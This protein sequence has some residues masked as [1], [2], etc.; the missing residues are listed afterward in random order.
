MFNNFDIRFEK[1]KCLTDCSPSSFDEW[2][3]LTP[4]FSIMILGSQSSF[5]RVN[6]I[7]KDLWPFVDVERQV[8]NAISMTEL[9]CV[10]C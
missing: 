6:V 3:P 7:V 9:L 8:I 1:C 10:G 4:E 2:H 5:R